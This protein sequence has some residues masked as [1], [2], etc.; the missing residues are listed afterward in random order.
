MHIMK[1]S[2]NSHILKINWLFL[3]LAIALT[4]LSIFIGKYPLTISGVL[5]SEGIQTLVFLNIRLPRVLM[6]LI[7]GFGLSIAG[8]IYQI[9]LKNNLAAPDI[10]G[11]GSGA[12]A[13]A[14]FGILFFSSTI[15]VT[16]C[17]FIGA[18]LAVLLT[19]TLSSL[20]N[21]R[22][23]ASI[24][25]SGICVHALAQTVLMM[26]KIMA[27]PEKQLSSIEYWIMGSLNGIS[28]RRLPFN[29]CLCLICTVIL[30]LMHRHILILS[31]NDSEAKM[32]GEDVNKI[33]FIILII[34]TLMVSSI[35][36]LTGLISFIG[37]I[38]PHIARLI[39]KDNKL[40]TMF[41][42]GLT[43]SII[44]LCADIFA[45]SIATSELPVS[46]FTNLV[47]VPFL[48]LLIIRRKTNA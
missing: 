27:D 30:F 23:N 34:T 28:A 46:I 11:V 4:I 19:L 45:R 29:I 15:A 7:G 39:N 13:G 9:I 32:L 21:G 3:I 10:I 22:N 16:T 24:V 1:H 6:A 38:G 35:I 31:N 33:R 42:S 43:G 14:A 40:N 48:L 20:N 47:G 25:L 2:T 36:S 37:L 17:S 18:L 5:N 44:L 26:L 41:L 8:F 12:S